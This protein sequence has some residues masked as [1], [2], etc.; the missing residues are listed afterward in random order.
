MRRLT[1]KI[2]SRKGET[3]IEILVSILI[4]ALS[5]LLVAAMFGAAGRIN[6]TIRD[7][8]EQFYQSVTEVE[9]QQGTP[10]KGVVEYEITDEEDPQKG[11]IDVEIFTDS[12]GT[13]SGY[14]QSD[15]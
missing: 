13:F 7:L 11:S 12:N 8:D 3:L 15:D 4:V 5:A 2:R 6:I 1:A 14:S 9:S 10:S